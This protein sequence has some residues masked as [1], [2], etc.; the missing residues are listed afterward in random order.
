[1]FQKEQISCIEETSR[2]SPRT[3]HDALEYFHCRLHECCL[4]L[5]SKQLIQS[6]SVF[7]LWNAYKDLKQFTTVE[8]LTALEYERL[9]LLLHSRAQETRQSVNWS[10]IVDVFEDMKKA[11]ISP[12]ASTA[13]MAITAYGRTG[14]LEHATAVF[15]SLRSELS[16]AAVR[17][18][19]LYERYLWACLFSGKIG[20]AARVVKDMR[21]VVDPSSTYAGLADLIE[22]C[23]KR[24]NLRPAVPILDSFTVAEMAI[25]PT[26]LHKMATYLRQGYEDLMKIARKK[27]TEDAL[28]VELFVAEFIKRIPKRNMPESAI[29]SPMRGMFTHDRLCIIM[30][31]LT[32]ALPKITPTAKT[33]DMLLDVY[34]AEKNFKRCSFVLRLMQK[35]N[36]QASLYTTSIILK[37]FGTSL[38]C[39]DTQALYDMLSKSRDVNV[40]SAFVHLYA[41]KNATALAEIVLQ[42]MR[43]QNLPMDSDSHAVLLQ[44]YI[45]QGQ[46]GRALQWLNSP[47]YQS[48][49]EVA[50]EDPND[51]AFAPYVAAMDA[52]LEQGDWKTCIEQYEAMLSGKLGHVLQRNRKIVK[53]TV[54]ATC[55]QG[56]WDKCESLLR[57]R[58]VE[59][60]SNTATRIVEHLLRLS[61]GGF[62]AVS[63]ASIVRAVQALERVL[64][65]HIKEPNVARIIRMLG[66]RGQGNDAYRLY[67]WVRG[68]ISVGKGKQ[69]V[70]SKERCS[71]PAIYLAMIEAATR[72]SDVR[73]AERAWYDLAYRA[74]FKTEETCISRKRPARS[75]Y[76][77][78]MNAY[79]ERLPA[80][81]L[82]RV[83]K[84]FERMLKDGLSPTV[85]TYNTLIKSFV[86]A[87]NVEAAYQIFATMLQSETKPD[88][89]TTNEIIRGLVGRKDWGAVEKFVKTM[90]D[91]DERLEVDIVTFNL[92][93]QGFLRLESRSVKHERLLIAHQDWKKIRAR[94]RATYPLTSDT[95]WDVFESAIG[96]KREELQNMP[97]SEDNKIVSKTNLQL[98]SP[99]K[100]LH[101]L[102]AQ[103]VEKQELQKEQPTPQG[104]SMPFFG[105]QAAKLRA[106]E[107]TYKL[108]MK[109]F[110]SAGDPDSAAMVLAW[111]KRNA[112]QS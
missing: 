16:I 61:K 81:S 60:T 92:L 89:W 37:A 84:A 17:E 35:Y 9:M 1:S 111:W 94:K 72:N 36:I 7:G 4:E 108:F 97:A 107:V 44:S 45:R 42:D 23:A 86:N 96:H 100:V 74:Q 93:I 62:P 112:K 26:A 88:S 66:E 48:L 70:I 59:F 3:P 78:L 91:H 95:I 67:R 71:Q 31:L 46:T 8:P 102:I 22:I 68:E 19:N 57:N 87:G 13:C 83:K 101:D 77:L 75:F 49:V 109:A 58:K 56:D 41:K 11:R 76:N 47:D 80:P 34:A 33:C 54:T 15:T 38:S 25:N 18:Y 20:V 21:N 14:K 65:V 12:T 51:P 110:I 90:R 39:S 28:S 105:S 10:R 40:Y 53:I 52:W 106:N 43:K 29:P 98:D 6:A 50:S 24:G 73:K 79:A 5:D 104:N 69:L 85:V 55:A 63:G 99:H 103:R 32:E 64:D 27:D 2:N 82:T 30:E